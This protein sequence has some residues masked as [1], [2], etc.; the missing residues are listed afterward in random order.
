MG[1][2][3]IAPIQIIER[4][5]GVLLSKVLTAGIARGDPRG[6]NGGSC[7]GSFITLFC[8]CRS[9]LFA[10]VIVMYKVALHSY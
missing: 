5:P 7:I 2:L 9:H 4:L 1:G 10:Q 6:L 8:T 3:R